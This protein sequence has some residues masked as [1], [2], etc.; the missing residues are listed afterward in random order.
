MRAIVVT[1]GRNIGSK[2]MPSDRWRLFKNHLQQLVR[3]HG[4]TVTAANDGQGEWD[5]VPEANHVV[6]GVDFSD[7]QASSSVLR[8]R[9]A[10]SLLAERHSQDA[11]ALIADGHSDLITGEYS[12][13]LDEL[14]AAEAIGEREGNPIDARSAAH[15][16]SR[17]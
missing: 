6:V 7:D 3:A 8:L 16:A 17:A 2:P 14:N 5:D 12:T 11:I 9:A 10:L 15:L 1:I 4:Y 13:Y